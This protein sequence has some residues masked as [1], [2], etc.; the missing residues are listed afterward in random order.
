ML[1][2]I[3]NKYIYNK[4]FFVCMFFNPFIVRIVNRKNISNIDYKNNT[5]TFFSSN[6]TQL[7]ARNRKQEL[8][9]II[10]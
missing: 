6:T 5:I 1:H 4:N 7:L 8:K 10:K 9:K 3:Y 2:I